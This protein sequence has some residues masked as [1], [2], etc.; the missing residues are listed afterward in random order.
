MLETETGLVLE[1]ET[2]PVLGAGLVLDTVLKMEFVLKAEA[3]GASTE[4]EELL[5]VDLVPEAVTDSVLKATMES[6]L[7]VEVDWSPAET[8]ELMADARA[9]LVLEAP[10]EAV[11]DESTLEDSDVLEIEVLDEERRVADDEGRKLEEER[12][13]MLVL[14]DVDDD[15]PVLVAEDVKGVSVTL[16]SGIAEETLADSVEEELTDSLEE[17]LADLVKKLAVT[18]ASVEDDD[19]ADTTLDELAVTAILVE[20]DDEVD[21]VLREST[22][23]LTAALET[24]DPNLLV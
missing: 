18:A 7:E 9:E 4:E 23:E 15:E 6:V 20:D 14:K 22:V 1:A 19:G 16:A 21:T 11:D 8:A 3:L 13:D 17:T 12:I 5:L 2:E 24:E 10:G